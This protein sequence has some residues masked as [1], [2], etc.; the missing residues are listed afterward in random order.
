MQLIEFSGPAGGIDIE[1][2][3]SWNKYDSLLRALFVYCSVVTPRIK[4]LLGRLLSGQK[5][6]NRN[7]LGG[8]SFFLFLFFF[9]FCLFLPFLGPLPWHM[10]VPRLEVELELQPPSYTTATAMRDP[11]CVC[12]LYHS[13]QQCWILNPLSKARD[14][15]RNLMVLSRIR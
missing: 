12:N 10:E 11:S 8:Y 14:P 7:G 4:G 13:S 15:T 5:Y 3:C 1:N 2:K 6:P 9:F